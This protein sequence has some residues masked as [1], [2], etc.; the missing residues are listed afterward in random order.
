M[1]RLVGCVAAV[2]RGVAWL[3]IFCNSPSWLLQWL[4]RLH[5]FC[6]YPGQYRAAITSPEMG[7]PMAT[8]CSNA[9]EG[10]GA[11]MGPIAC[12]AVASQRMLSSAHEEAIL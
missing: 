4:T 7:G 12:W 1:G 2:I 3:P 6:I 9:R 5:V 11:S 8:E 10:L